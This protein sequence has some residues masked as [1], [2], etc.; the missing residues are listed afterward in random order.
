MNGRYTLPS[1]DT[2]PLDLRVQPGYQAIVDYVRRE[3]T[4]GRIRA[5]DRLPPERKLA[6]QFGV[7]RETLRQAL[8]VLESSGQVVIHRGAHG[9][10]VVQPI[11]SDPAAIKQ[12]IRHRAH[13]ILELLEFRSITESAAA[14]LAAERRTVENLRSMDDAQR[15]LESATTTQNSRLADT[16]FHLAVAAAA[17]NAKLLLSI[18]D[19]RVH[20]FS[21]VDFLSFQFAKQSSYDAHGRILDAIRAKDASAAKLAMVE[22]LATT[23]IE[24]E[25]LLDETQ[26]EQP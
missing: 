26:P 15:D 25:S 16:S 23:Q 18:E 10:A 19:A 11:I 9:G 22:H 7:A 4:L 6:E 5:G 1:E 21:P 14:E 3:M 24:F 17:Q 13:D 12:D 20:M 8:K 2:P